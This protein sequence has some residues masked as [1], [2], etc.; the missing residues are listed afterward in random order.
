MPPQAATPAWFPTAADFRAWLLAHHADTAELWVGFYKKSAGKT[1]L[2]YAEA[3][4]EA[5]CFGWIDGIIKSLDAARFMHRFTPRRRGSTWS[6]INL[7]HIA[8]LTAAGRMHPAGVAAFE[9]RSAKRTG[10]YTYERP[11][12]PAR[13]QR[14]PE[15]FEKLFR[16]NAAA[17]RF[18]QAQPPGYQRNIIWWVISAK[19]EA[20]QQRRLGFAIADSAAGRRVPEESGQ[21]R[22]NLPAG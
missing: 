22:K 12:R 20:T 21:S 1:G 4:D 5:L 18:W 3:V 8:R 19:Q 11:D 6:N 15:K 17:W 16:A 10:T 9:A 13:P 2:T 7:R 14:F